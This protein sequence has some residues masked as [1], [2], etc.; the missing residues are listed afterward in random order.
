MA[1]SIL[2]RKAPEDWGRYETLKLE[3]DARAELE[4][5]GIN[6]DSVI[7]SVVAEMESMV[8]NGGETGDENPSETRALP[9]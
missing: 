7:E 6:P 4:A 9:A 8:D 3:I 2:E 1:L 5:M